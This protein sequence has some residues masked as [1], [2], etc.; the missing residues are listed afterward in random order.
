[1]ALPLHPASAVSALVDEILLDAI[2]ALEE[3]VELGGPEIRNRSIYHC[4]HVRNHLVAQPASLGRQVDAH[5][6]AVARVAHS[7]HE[8]VLFHIVQRGYR[9]I[10]MNADLLAQF[11][12]SQSIVLGQNAQV[13]PMADG[14]ALARDQR[15]QGRGVQTMNITDRP[16]NAPAHV[17]EDARVL[18]DRGERALAGPLI[19]VRSLTSRARRA[20]TPVALPLGTPRRRIPP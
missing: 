18:V 20:A 11:A 1:M 6:A 5:S 15:F 9:S 14:H 4:L 2:H 10:G 12:L 16:S 19:A 17:I 8:T 3:R 13:I 7:R